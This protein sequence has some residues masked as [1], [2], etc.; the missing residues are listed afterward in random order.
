MFHPRLWPGK[1]IAMGRKHVEQQ[2]TIDAPPQACFDALTDYETFADWQ[3][4]VKSCEV[5]SR[6]DHGRGREVELA[7]DAKV[8]TVHYRLRYEYEE[9]HRIG[10]DY[11][12]GDVKE[13]DGEYIFEDLGDGRTLAT[14]SLAIDPGVWVP[15][16]LQRL[17]SEGVMRGHMKDLKR[18]VESTQNAGAAT[19]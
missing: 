2:I 11:L 6:D 17:L 5:L 7:V 18:R 15:G 14:Y 19:R 4:A 10:W 1:E 3:E 16:P 13:I 12:E 8:K 9:P